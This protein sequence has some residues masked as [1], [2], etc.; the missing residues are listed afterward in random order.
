MFNPSTRS[1]CVN[2]AQLIATGGHVLFL[3]PLPPPFLP[4]VSPAP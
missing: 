4:P 1:A 3:N 2:I